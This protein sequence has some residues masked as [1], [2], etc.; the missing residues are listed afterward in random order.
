M[1]EIV[2]ARLYLVL[3][4]SNAITYDKIITYIGEQEEENNEDEETEDEE[5]EDE[6]TEDEET[7]DDGNL[8]INSFRKSRPKILSL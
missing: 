3:K 7:V 8:Q 5:T 4:N 6:E 2:V 1:E